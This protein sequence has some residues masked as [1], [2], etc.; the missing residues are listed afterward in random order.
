MNNKILYIINVDWYFRLHWLERAEYFKKLGNEVHIITCFTDDR[1]KVELQELG[2]FCHSIPLKRKSTALSSE[3]FTLCSL[4]RLIKT[5]KPDLMHCI[6]VKPNI[7]VGLLN[8]IFFKKPIMFGVTGLGVIFSSNEVYFRIIRL[9]SILLYRCVSSRNSRF[10]FEN[11]EDLEL[12]EGAGIVKNRNGLVIKGAGIN[13]DYFLASPPTFNNEILFAARLLEDK[14][15]RCLLDAREL[16]LERGCN[17]RI[18]VAGIVDND[19]SSAIPISQIELWHRK[20][21]I[22]WL[23]NVE[24]MPSIIAKND[25]VCLPTTYGEG[26][27]R[28]LIEAASCGRAIVTTDVPGCREI[29]SDGFNGYLAKPRDAVSLANCLESLLCS[30]DKLLEFGVNGREKVENEFSQEMVFEKTH[31]VYTELLKR[32]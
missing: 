3:L 1:I 23:G 4:Y 2:F 14:G 16:L 11:C 10:I 24:N 21:I 19:V 18:N 13:L 25:I 7:Y 30:P 26:V 20:G 8:R 17:V 28:I 5:I 9:L 22:N 15:L 12:F 6:T 32:S 27:P 29:V 31:E